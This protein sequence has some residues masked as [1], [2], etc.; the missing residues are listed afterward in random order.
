[1]LDKSKVTKQIYSY[2]YEWKPY[3][4]PI[5]WI[6]YHNVTNY[7]TLLLSST[8]SSGPMVQTVYKKNQKATQAGKEL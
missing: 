5:R 1:M 2:K 4:C 3:I 8:D 6:K 7:V